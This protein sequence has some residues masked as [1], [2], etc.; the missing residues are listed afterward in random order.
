MKTVEMKDGR[1]I[2]VVT[3]GETTF[4]D[5]AVNPF[6]N[7]KFIVCGVSRSVIWYNATPVWCYRQNYSDKKILEL[8]YIQYKTSDE[9]LATKS[10]YIFSVFITDTD[11]YS[12]VREKTAT[13]YQNE[14]IMLGG[15]IF[16]L[17][18]SNGA[19]I[20]KYDTNQSLISSYDFT[21][22]TD[23]PFQNFDLNMITEDGDYLTLM[24]AKYSHYSSGYYFYTQYIT[25]FDSSFNVMASMSRSWTIYFFQ[26]DCPVPCKADNLYHTRSAGLFM[27]KRNYSFS[28]I[29]TNGSQQGAFLGSGENGYWYYTLSNRTYSYYTWINYN[30]LFKMD[31]TTYEST[32]ANLPTGLNPQP[33]RHNAISLFSDKLILSCKYQSTTFREY[34][35]GLSL[36]RNLPL[37]PQAEV[38]SILL[39]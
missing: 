11:A 36:I 32:S 20:L 38:E 7:S 35:L 14:Y 9:P 28:L 33:F 21:A 5:S 24:S 6:T 30:Y 16:T 39:S 27:E 2:M 17:D 29:S 15:Y 26:I 3:S 19:R 4:L 10:K 34:S 18:Y 25:R 37:I 8:W 12:E 1:K 22:Q 13:F 31:T 23:V